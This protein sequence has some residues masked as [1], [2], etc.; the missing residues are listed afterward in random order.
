MENRPHLEIHLSLRSP[1]DDKPEE[2]LEEAASQ[3]AR[4]TAQQGG[5]VVTEE[6]SAD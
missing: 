5:K 1:N 3:L 2:R 4:L 6:H